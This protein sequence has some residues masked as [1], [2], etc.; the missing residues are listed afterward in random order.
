MEGTL[1]HNSRTIEKFE[2]GKKLGSKSKILLLCS[3]FALFRKIRPGEVRGAI[4]GNCGLKKFYN[5]GY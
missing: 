1:V 4:C 2:T 3:G 5:F